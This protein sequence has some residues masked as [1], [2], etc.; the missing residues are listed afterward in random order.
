MSRHPLRSPAHGKSSHDLDGVRQFVSDG[1]KPLTR[2][3][4]WPRLTQ[5]SWK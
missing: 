3:G 4:T 1:L 5:I 2:T